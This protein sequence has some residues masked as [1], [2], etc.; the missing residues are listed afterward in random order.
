MAPRHLV[1]HKATIE[2]AP[3]LAETG[4]RMFEN[5]FGDQ[6]DPEDMAQ[7]L[8]S[9]FSVEQIS[10]ELEDPDS[11]FL[12]AYEG[13]DIVGYAK[14]KTG[15][16]PSSIQGKNPIELVRIYVDQACVGRGYGA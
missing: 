6:N 3:L 1:I 7:Y 15:D 4:A 8:A 13:G 16:S 12:L 14:L 11:I 2:E 10:S 9:A 5:A